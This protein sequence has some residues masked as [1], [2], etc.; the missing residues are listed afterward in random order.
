MTILDAG[1]VGFND[2]YFFLDWCAKSGKS[3]VN[4]DNLTYS[5]KQ[6]EGATQ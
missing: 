3:V 2:S 1:R 6:Y 4:L 5:C